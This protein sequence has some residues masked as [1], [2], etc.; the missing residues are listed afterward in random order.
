MAGG[1]TKLG[2]PFMPGCSLLI[3]IRKPEYRVFPP[4]CSDD[5]QSDGKTSGRESTGNR[6]RGQSPHIYRAR[7]AEQQEFAWAEKV[8]VLL[9]FI[10]CRSRN[11]CGVCA[12]VNSRLGMCDSVESLG[13]KT[14]S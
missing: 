10:D 8:W 13:F 7:I 3:G 12:I 14:E 11:W 9:Q 4:V 2:L 5:L 1:N 6:E